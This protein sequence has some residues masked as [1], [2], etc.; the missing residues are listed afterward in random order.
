M[1][2]FS[3]E[4]INIRT[5]NILLKESKKYFNEI[6]K[7]EKINIQY[8][9]I[10]FFNSNLP[11]FENMNGHYFPKGFGSITELYMSYTNR[12]LK[13]SFQPKMNI[14]K[15]YNIT[16]P[17]KEKEFSVLNDVPLK[18]DFLNSKSRNTGLEFKY[19]KLSM[20]YG[21]WDRWW[22]PGIHNSLTLSNNSRGF[23]H[24]FIKLNNMHIP[25]DIFINSTYSVSNPLK[26]NHNN[27]FFIS[28]WSV[29]VYYKNIELGIA[30]QVESGGNTDIEWSINDAFFILINRNK[31]KYW[32]YSNS[33]YVKVIF[34][35]SNLI[36][37]YETAFPK[38]IFS[39][40]YNPKIYYDHLRATNI[41]L[42]KYG[43]MGMKNV[44][45]GFEYAR[46][47]QGLYFNKIPTQNWYSNY[48][49]D[50]SSYG[51]RRYGAH[52]GTDSDD[53]FVYLGNINKKH[54]IIYQFNFERHGITFNFPPEVKFEQTLI[55]SYKHDS[56]LFFL[57]YE[58][59][60]F[61]HYGFVDKNNNVW[62][63]IPETDS[64]QRTKS[65]IFGID[66]LIKY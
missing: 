35:K 12:F 10:N 21:N 32:D 38:Q 7:K 16:P 25:N 5:H 41:G 50:Y 42:R 3:Q 54:S 29:N 57:Q 24:Y 53:F 4:I 23:Y 52:S 43:F 27:E 19:K 15:V 20:G 34:P 58:N 64:L 48:K 44:V 59:E 13:F 40:N 6:S 31:E 33:Y 56:M 11:N 22:G 66:Y 62:E 51:G 37:F 26:N 39:E 47:I 28:R 61:N 8:S 63:Q 18:K 49:Y 17:I 9:Q 45:V 30:S 2:I 60:Y 1:F 55:L 14:S 65:L 36:V 46:L